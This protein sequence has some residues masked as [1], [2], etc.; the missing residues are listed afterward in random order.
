MS[1]ALYEY[2]QT[3]EHFPSF[4]SFAASISEELIVTLK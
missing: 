1:Q 2:F 3:L 4:S